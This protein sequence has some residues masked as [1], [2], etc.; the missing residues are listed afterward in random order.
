[1]KEALMEE[2]QK[3][4]ETRKRKN[5]EMRAVA[6]DNQKANQMEVKS[7]LKLPIKSRK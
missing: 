3:K 5:I 6:S 4:K 7:K 1:M 2:K